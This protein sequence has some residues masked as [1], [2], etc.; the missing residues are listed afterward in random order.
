MLI[1]SSLRKGGKGGAFLPSLSKRRGEPVGRWMSAALDGVL[2]NMTLFIQVYLCGLYLPNKYNN[3]GTA[4]E[5][6]ETWA[7]GRGRNPSS[8]G[9][10]CSRL[11]SA[12]GN[13][14]W[15]ALFSKFSLTLG[16]VLSWALR[17][18]MGMEWA[19]DTHR[20]GTH[21]RVMVHRAGCW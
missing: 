12:G 1:F 9:A 21:T 11:G 14:G 7:G 10:R 3:G 6:G 13:F 20:P 2:G 15:L 5:K 19:A 18:K 4:A 16:K 8:K 17:T